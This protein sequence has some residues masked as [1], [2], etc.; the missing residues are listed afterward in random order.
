MKMTQRAG[1]LPLLFIF[2]LFFS[3]CQIQ[4]QD[5]S[6]QVRGKVFDELTGKPL[7]K[8]SLTLKVSNQELKAQSNEKGEFRFSQ[9]PI[10][11][12][13]LRISQ[14]GYS[15]YLISDLLISAGKESILEIG[16]KYSNYEME[17]VE[18]LQKSSRKDNVQQV[19][20][21][22]F[23]VEES[24]R[25]AA[26]YYDPARL[27]ATYP[28]IA[29]SSDESNS[30][31]IR[32]NSPNGVLWRLEGVDI[33]NPN[34]SS[35]TGTFTDR[36]TQ[37]GG[38]TNILSNQLLTDSR[39][40]TSAFDPQ[41]G[42]ALSGIFDMRLRKGN[43]EKT[44][45]TVQPSL[46]GIDLAAEGPLSAEGDASFL[47]NYRYST[48]G[49]FELMGIEVSPEKINYQDLAFN[50]SLPTQKA[51]NFTVFGMGGLSSNI[52]EAPRVDSLIEEGRDRFD[53]DFYSNMGAVGMTHS[54]LI[55]TNTLWKSVIAASAIES[56]KIEN[57]V[58]TPDELMP[59]AFDEIK[60][61]KLSFRSSL[62]HRFKNSFSLEEGFN[63][64][65][66]GY[67]MLSQQ[68][69]LETIGANPIT[70]AQASGNSWLLQP[71][72]ASTFSPNPRLSMKFGLHG[73]YFSLNGDKSVE[74]R[75]SIIYQ[76]AQNSKLTAAYGLHSQLQLFG[77]Y[78]S[79]FEGQFPNQD[80]GFTKAHHAVL[81]FTQT[82]GQG[83]SL[84]VEPYFQKLF[85]VP[86]SQNPNSTF[87]A[88]NLFEGYVIDSLVNEGTGR[89]Y[90]IELSIDQ[91]LKNG[92]YYM[93]NTSLY[94][95]KYTGADGIERDTRFNGNYILNAVGGKEFE[96][97][98]KKGDKKMF[99]INISIA[100]Q[101]GFRGSKIDLVASDLAKRTVF[102]T[103]DP[104]TERFPNYFRTDLRFSFKKDKTG[105]TRTFA[106]DLLNLTNRPNV[107][108]QRYD[109]VSKEVV[110]KIGLG[111]IPLMSY[112]LEF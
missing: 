59:S 14:E 88:I 7:D 23:T 67:T 2:T 21:R 39:I 60:Q 9:V 30:L 11:R 37:S 105:F 55:G 53:V 85:N 41:Y 111:L 43:D 92:Y 86:I 104:F 65:R 108:F 96:R 57:F 77:T 50:L 35:S 3:V 97:I 36:L 52:F 102:I 40:Q 76:L 63:L 48:I 17:D 19:S 1:I 58:R 101:G 103:T 83:L 81:S 25:I 61:S 98:S 94:E 18:I 91:D 74:P 71:F 84:T 68:T 69:S 44:E 4:A 49:L 46:I 24:Q 107:S 56:E 26:T 73:M 12:H 10:G 33:V 5:F 45:F 6:Q 22:V 29:V 8:A 64:T 99:G 34:H 42:N 109:I 70:L 16:M 87:S 110:N 75:A 54:L 100:Y 47:V 90:G 82:L 38:G 62:S 72:V 89:N 95:S 31:I 32:G 78:F 66:I 80:I 27:A 93:L 13:T 28:G 106:I 20:T 15:P 79:E 51:G 112:R